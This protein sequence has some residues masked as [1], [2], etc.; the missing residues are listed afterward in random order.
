MKRFLMKRGW[1]EV[2]GDEGTTCWQAPVTLTG[3]PHYFALEAAYELETTGVG[4]WAYSAGDLLTGLLR[5]K[6]MAF[7]ESQEMAYFAKHGVYHGV[8]PNY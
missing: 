6:D 7:S 2:P 5:A 4:P 1:K 8:P 3:I